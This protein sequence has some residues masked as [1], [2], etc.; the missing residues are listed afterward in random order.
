MFEYTTSPVSKANDIVTGIE[1]PA[2]IERFSERILQDSINANCFFFRIEKELKERP[3][4]NAMSNVLTIWELLN[5]FPH[6]SKFC[7][8]TQSKTFSC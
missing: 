1:V 8:K 7:A 2:K 6:L 5:A 4:I 3:R